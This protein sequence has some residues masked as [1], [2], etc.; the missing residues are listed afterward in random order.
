MSGGLELL[1]R[2]GTWLELTERASPQT[3]HDYRTS[4][5][6]FVA[7]YLLTEGRPGSLTLVT[8]DDV[9]AYFDSL[10]RHGSQRQTFLRAAK[11]FYELWAYPRGFCAVNPVA[12]FRVK[13]APRKPVKF[14]SAEEMRAFL[15]AAGEFPDQRALPTCLLMFGTAARVSSVAGA[16]PEDVNLEGR[17]IWWRFAKGAKPYES[18]LDPAHSLVGAQRLLELQGYHPKNGVHHGTLVGVGHETI[19]KWVKAAGKA[20][21]LPEDKSVPH[22][23]RRTMATLMAQADV[24][25]VDWV[26]VMNHSG[27]SEYIRYAGTTDDRLRAAVSKVRVPVPVL[28][29][30]GDFHPR[31][32]R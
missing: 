25:L 3:I 28:G 23:L 6:R 27:P 13:R 24:P 16:M 14:F 1:Q 4:M 7:D 17:K 22:T 32:R 2:W 10:P 9:L 11:S 12:D 19:R 5:V 29:G 31:R 15:A 20:A 30:G 18:P 21:G 8:E 26:H